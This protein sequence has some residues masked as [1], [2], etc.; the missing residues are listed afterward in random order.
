[1]SYYKTGNVT[2]DSTGIGG[3]VF[4]TSV[5]NGTC[6]PAWTST[7]ATTYTINPTNSY[8]STVSINESGITMKEDS[9]IVFGGR[10]LKKTLDAIESRLAIL[11]PNIHFE[12]EWEE[13]KRLGDE[14][15]AL[16]KVLK[17]KMV[18]W[19]ILKRE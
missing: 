19:D 16:E 1:M 6:S 18:T 15:R 8:P 3:S 7:S 2:I 11:D 13:L 4:T 17:E 5:S 10:S 9:D 14:Y 12:A